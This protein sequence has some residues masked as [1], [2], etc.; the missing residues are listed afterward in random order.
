M[1]NAR[2]L[3]FFTEFENDLGIF[4]EM[5]YILFGKIYINLQQFQVIPEK[6]TPKETYKLP[7][8]RNKKDKKPKLGTKIFDG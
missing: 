4:Y 2:I 8:S 3:R 5:K 6:E 7:D 1:R